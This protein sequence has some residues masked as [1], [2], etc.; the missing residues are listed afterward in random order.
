LLNRKT[1][2][3]AGPGEKKKS[4]RTVA[5]G[6][7]PLEKSN[8]GEGGKVNAGIGAGRGN[9]KKEKKP[10]AYGVQPGAAESKRK[11]KLPGYQNHLSV[12]WPPF[13]VGVKGK[14]KS[15]SASKK[16]WK[17]IKPGEAPFLKKPK[18]NQVILPTKSVNKV[19]RDKNVSLNKSEE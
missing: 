3:A 8:G 1:I 19:A 17:K 7:G 11:E 13:Q 16:V 14:R 4:K 10:S 12:G 2:R 9:Q 18:R 6:S 5:L 15:P